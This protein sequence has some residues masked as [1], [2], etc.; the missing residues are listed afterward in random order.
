MRA[1][2]Y[3]NVNITVNCTEKCK[4]I[5]VAP[6]ATNSSLSATRLVTLF[7]D[8]PTDILIWLEGEHYKRTMYSILATGMQPAGSLQR[9]HALQW[10]SEQHLPVPPRVLR[11]CLAQ[12]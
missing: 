11:V 5:A 9:V 2:A 6:C 12:S 3:G 8:R 4:V 7:G 1:Q 10:P